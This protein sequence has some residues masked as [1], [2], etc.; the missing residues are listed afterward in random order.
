MVSLG[1]GEEEEQSGAEGG[2]GS[3]AGQG[4]PHTGTVKTPSEFF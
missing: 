1:A 3:Q 4:G 2:G